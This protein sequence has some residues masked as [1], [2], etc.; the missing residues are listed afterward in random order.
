MIAIRYYILHYI[1]GGGRVTMG[2]QNTQ[3]DNEMILMNYETEFRI[4]DF[5]RQC[6]GCPGVYK[7]R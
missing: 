7:R 3:R 5:V 2:T 4:M 1:C 6:S